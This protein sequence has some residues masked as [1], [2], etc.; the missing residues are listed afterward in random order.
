M[1][2]SLK[3]SITISL[4]LGVMIALSA[5]AHLSVVRPPEN[6]FSPVR[7]SYNFG[8]TG[9]RALYQLLEESGFTVKRWRKS[10][11]NLKTE[12]EPGLLI[13]IDPQDAG[14]NLNDGD[15]SY[16]NAREGVAIAEWI[17]RGGRLLFI[18]RQT[19][20]ILP[21]D[22]NGDSIAIYPPDNAEKV[23]NPVTDLVDEQSNRFL[24]QPSAITRDLQQLVFSK[25]AA[26]IGTVAANTSLPLSSSAINI[27]IKGQ[28][29]GQKTGK[30]KAVK[31]D[32]EADEEV[33][34]TALYAPVFHLQDEKGALLAD[35]AFEDGRVVIL[36][37][38]FVV[39]NQGIRLGS[40]PTLVMNLIRDLAVDPAT[41]ENGGDVTVRQIY[42][43]EYHHG[44]STGNSLIFDYFRGTPVLLTA[45]QLL[46]LGACLIFSLGRRFSR[47]LPLQTIDRHSPLEFVSSMASLQ[48]AAEARDLAIENIYPQFR[49]E[50]CLHLGLPVN[51]HNDAILATLRQQ[52]REDFSL[53]IGRIMV[54]CEL[55]I[56]GEHLQDHQLV[57][58]ISR[59]RSAQRD[60]GSNKAGSPAPR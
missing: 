12:S 16:K 43:D 27:N 50:L 58:L 59:I 23:S 57:G 22:L 11:D 20:P 17:G 6:E 34:V 29:S 56:R 24:G 44:F 41:D 31:D 13:V 60:F 52:S 30:D 14:K 33:T 25:L 45:L 37:D 51:A 32:D 10:F 54:E 4:I 7:S 15:I 42:F 3:I 55:A 19:S 21:L 9:T 48:Q 18:S 49:R 8:P 5:I 1:R 38:P 47:P 36:T 2:R 28:D 39:S 35:Y 26:R 53:E 46:L 40:N